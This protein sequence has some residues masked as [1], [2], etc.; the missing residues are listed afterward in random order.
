MAEKCAESVVTAPLIP[1][2]LLSLLEY[3]EGQRR[4]EFQED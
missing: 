4:E 2:G 3:I 1:E